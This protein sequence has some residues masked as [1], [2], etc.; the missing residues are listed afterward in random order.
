MGGH[1]V[2]SIYPHSHLMGVGGLM[3]KTHWDECPYWIPPPSV[4]SWDEGMGYWVFPIV[5]PPHP[6]GEK[7][8]V[9]RGEIGKINKFFPFPPSLRKK[10]PTPP[11]P[12]RG[13]KSFFPIV[14]PIPPPSTWDEGGGGNDGGEGKNQ[15]WKKLKV[16]KKLIVRKT[17]Y[18]LTAMKTPYRRCFYGTSTKKLSLFCLLRRLLAEADDWRFLQSSFFA[19]K[20]HK[21]APM[22]HST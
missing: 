11:H 17:P 13:V 10:F 3:W 18:M 15:W 2:F 14:P 22:R 5:S 1:W 19:P 8:R 12:C 20:K 6:H 21:N 7:C 4:P 16:G 9:G